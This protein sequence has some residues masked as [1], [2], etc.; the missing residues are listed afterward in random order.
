MTVQVRLA[1]AS[2]AAAIGEVFASAF[3]NDPVTSW[4]TPDAER[5]ARLL[6]R[7]NAAIARY[8]GIP[9]GATYVAIAAGAVVG[10]AIWRPPGRRPI[11]LRGMQFVVIAGAALG[12]SIPRTIAAGRAAVLARPR[13]PHWYLQLLGVHPDVQGTGV[14]SALVREQLA[15]VDAAR[16]L[17]CLETTAENLEF[18]GRLGFVV[19]GELAM[20]AGAPPEYALRRVATT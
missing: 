11:G 13:E 16:M 10:A 14:G 17:S 3:A 20:P 4:V 7:L 2:D 9:L 8:E 6:R 1:V 12:R 19:T 18:Y 15:R 5:R